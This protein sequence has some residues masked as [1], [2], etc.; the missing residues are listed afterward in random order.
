[1]TELLL[2]RGAVV[3]EEDNNRNTPLSIAIE[4]AK[5]AT[6]IANLL[7]KHGAGKEGTWKRY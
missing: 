2:K 5:K 1:M 6:E 7:I 3:T 4:T